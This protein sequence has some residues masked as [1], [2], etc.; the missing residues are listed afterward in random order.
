[1]AVVYVLEKRCYLKVS[2]LYILRPLLGDSELKW[3]AVAALR[4]NPPSAADSQHGEEVG[5]KLGR[6]ADLKL[7]QGNVGTSLVNSQ[8][9]VEPQGPGVGRRGRA[10]FKHLKELGLGP[11]HQLLLLVGEAEPRIRVEVL[12]EDLRAPEVPPSEVILN[13]AHRLSH[14]VGQGIIGLLVGRLR[15][16]HRGKD[17]ADDLPPAPQA[18]QDQEVRVE[19]IGEAG[20]GRVLGRGQ[21]DLH[22]R[23]TASGRG[24]V[25]PY[26]GIMLGQVL[27]RLSSRDG[28]E[29]LRGGPVHQRPVGR[30]AV[31]VA[32]LVPH[33][34][35]ALHLAA[36]QTIEVG[37]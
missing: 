6:V 31:Q 15:Q 30:Q 4:D 8:D 1:M 17:L 18:K 23:G 35:E 14:R 22:L 25:Q 27:R 10:A 24:E 33:L 3:L 5:V 2:C 20:R 29:E 36:V 34:P 37:L 11:A 21:G 16:R 9:L 12:P 26:D 13:A 32:F 7:D 19:H 28:F